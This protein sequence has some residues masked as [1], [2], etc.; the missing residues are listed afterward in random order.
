MS[1]RLATIL[2]A[3][4]VGFSARMEQDEEGTLD[5]LKGLRQIIDAEIE[6]HGG[7]VF[8]SAGDSVIAEFASP[9]EAVE[10]ATKGRLHLPAAGRPG[11][12]QD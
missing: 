4:A 2:A 5:I 8:S 1:R 10:C 3:D 6:N 11:V 7:R 12:G 9:V